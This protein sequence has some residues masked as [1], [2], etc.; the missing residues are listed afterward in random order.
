MNI[1][2]DIDDTLTNSF[3]YFM[4]FV[5]E[6]FGVSVSYCKENGI[7]Y[8]LLPE[9]WKEKELD[10]CKTYYDRV[11]EY[12]PFKADA[13]QTVQ[14]IKA[15]G[16]KIFILTARNDSMYTDPYRTT[17]KE[18][19]NGNI[20][21][22]KLLCALDKATACADEKID[23]LIDDSINNCTAVSRKG[24]AVVLFTSKWNEKATVPFRRVGSWQE[25][26]AMFP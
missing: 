22:D 2:I 23:L 13:A 5:A 7:S 11:V 6:Y 14:K 8:C 3:D 21:Y 26:G 18:L 15:R 25:V 10:F 1:A 16:H 12:T 19:A 4:P 9:K 20:P 24:I 17:Q